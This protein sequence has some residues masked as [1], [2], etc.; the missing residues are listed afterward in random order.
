MRGGDGQ[1]G[2]VKC[3][4]R[5]FERRP[6]PKA[7][8]AHRKPGDSTRETQDSFAAHHLS[9]NFLPLAIRVWLLTGTRQDR[10]KC[11][12]RENLQSRSGPCNPP[13]ATRSKASDLVDQVYKN[14]APK[15][16]ARGPPK[17]LGIHRA[18]RPALGGNHQVGEI[19]IAS[20]PFLANR[21]SPNLFDAKAGER[22]AG[23]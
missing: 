7:I 9:K 11:G 3:L 18:D 2:R 15:W 16:R 13:T 14:E 5:T 23:S 19:R 10:R 12:I 4:G 17:P 8:E 6:T 20:G 22:G 21:A 1:P